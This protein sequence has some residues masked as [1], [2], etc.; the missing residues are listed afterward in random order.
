[1]LFEVF[2]IGDWRLLLF[3]KTVI[4]LMR[5]GI[6]VSVVTCSILHFRKLED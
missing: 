6:L 4:T 2:L 3:S 5:I 1:M